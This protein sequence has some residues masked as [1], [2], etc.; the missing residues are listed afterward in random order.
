MPCNDCYY[1]KMRKKY[2]WTCRV[3]MERL[4]YKF[5]YFITLTY[6]NVHLPADN[7]VSYNDAD[8]FL[9]RLRDYFKKVSCGFSY[10]LMSEYGGR[11][12]RPHYHMHLLTDMPLKEVSVIVSHLWQKGFIKIGRSS[13]KSILYTSAYHLLPK[14]HRNA[15]PRS[16]FHI[17]TRGLGKNYADE[18]AL[19]NL[20]RNRK[21][22]EFGG[23]RFNLPPYIAKRMGFTSVKTLQDLDLN[24]VYREFMASCYDKG[25]DFKESMR[26]WYHY[27][28]SFYEKMIVKGLKNKI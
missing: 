10:Y 19:F 15:Y 28:N 26:Q 18:N 3:I 27:C 11:T 14:E 20:S 9:D 24:E 4:F 1:C 7:G 13:L 6:D 8:Y 2:E 16:N 12:Q 17:F 25:F 5:G 22:F 21:V 23:F